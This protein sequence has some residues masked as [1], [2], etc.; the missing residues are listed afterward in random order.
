ME[1]FLCAFLLELPPSLW[2]ESLTCEN[3]QHRFCVLPS[4]GASASVTHPSGNVAS[5]LGHLLPPFPLVLP[6]P[7]SLGIAGT[8][9]RCWLLDM[10]QVQQRW[11]GE[12]LLPVRLLNTN[13][14]GAQRVT[15]AYR[16]EEAGYGELRILSQLLHVRYCALPLII[17]AFLTFTTLSSSLVVKGPWPGGSQPGGFQLSSDIYMR[18]KLWSYFQIHCG[19]IFSQELG[20]E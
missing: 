17:T 2:R 18:D 8:K 16:K 7:C 15:V 11:T 20:Q 1:L 4:A 10:G 3:E 6:W 14:E 5:C 13:L 19:H 12:I 9:A